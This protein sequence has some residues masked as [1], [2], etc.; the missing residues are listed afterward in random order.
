MVQREVASGWP[1]RRAARP[2]APRR[3]SPSSSCEVRVL[4]KVPRTVFHPEPNVDSALVVMRRRAPP[5]P[6]E[7]VALVHAGFAHRR[8]AL[9]GSLA[10]A[11]GAPDGIR[12]A[13]R[14]AL[15]PLGHPPDARAERLA[16]E[17]WPRLADGARPRAPRRAAPAV[18]LLSARCFGSAPTRRSTWSC[19]SARAATDGLHP[20]CSL[21][22]SIDLADEVIVEPKRLAARTRRLR[23]RGRRQ[24]RRARAL[25]A[26]RSR[27]GT[28]LPPLAITIEKRMPVAAG[29]GGGSADA[30]A[31]L[32]AANR[33]RRRPAR[34]ARSCARSPPASARTCPSQVEPRPRARQGVGRARRAGRRCRRSRRVLIPD[35]GR[36]LHRRGVR[37]ARPPRAAGATRS[38]PA[39]LRALARPSPAELSR[40][41]R[42]RPPAGR[43]LAAPGA[44][45]SGSTRC[46]AAGALGAAVSGSGPT[47]FGLFA[48]RAA[49]EAAAERLPGALVDRSCADVPS[50][51]SCRPGRWSPRWPPCSSRRTSSGAGAG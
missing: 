4:R 51:P 5:P 3:C 23:G 33:A 39:A 44:P 31:V 21:F 40:G 34:A 6:P 32:R 14:A 50:A 29:L 36:A 22:A 43:A 1:R 46:A 47:C 26:F 45:A 11:P 7:L 13:T 19:T 17:D 15:E 30:A 41:A 24:P 27:A 37:R 20:V 2:T 48:D 12:D 8:K 35:G 28:E 10:L 49:A 16:P 42:E 9:A 38:T 18:A 25:A